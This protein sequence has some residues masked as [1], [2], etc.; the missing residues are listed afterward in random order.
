MRRWAGESRSPSRGTRSLRR[1]FQ[2]GDERIEMYI[3]S[4]GMC[5]KA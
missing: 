5:S 3:A 4:F 1:L 2:R